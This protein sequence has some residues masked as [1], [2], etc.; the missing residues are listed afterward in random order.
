MN[1]TEITLYYYQNNF[2][3]CDAL[4]SP[5][6]YSSSEFESRQKHITGILIDSSIYY[7]S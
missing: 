5:F 3:C 4:R 1:S 2:D 6:L 7:V